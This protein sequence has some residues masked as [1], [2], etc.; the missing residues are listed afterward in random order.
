[1][2]VE[3]IGRTNPEDQ[4]TVIEYRKTV[5]GWTKFHPEEHAVTRIVFLGKCAEDGDCFAIYHAGYISFC[6]GK[7]NNGKYNNN[8]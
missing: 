1:M 8:K 7:L 2:R 5:R 3:M 6:K 4:N